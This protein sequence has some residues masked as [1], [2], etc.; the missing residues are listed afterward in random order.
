M[1]KMYFLTLINSRFNLYIPS[2]VSDDLDSLQEAVLTNKGDICDC[3]YNYAVIEE[4]Y[5]SH[6]MTP[7]HGWT[8]DIIQWYKFD[9]TYPE[10]TATPC[11]EPEE[12]HLDKSFGSNIFF[13]RL[14]NL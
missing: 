3:H 5:T 14:E 13:G 7:V 2:G 8:S 10:M 6:H 1:K 11:D 4:F 12:L 9:G